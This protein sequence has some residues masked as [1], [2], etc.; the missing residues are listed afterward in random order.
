ME[1]EVVLGDPDRLKATA[2]AGVEIIAVAKRAVGLRA[3]DLLAARFA[4]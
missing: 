2:G 3:A 1:A 4:F